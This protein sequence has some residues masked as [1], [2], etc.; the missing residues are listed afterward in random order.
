MA[1]LLRRSPAGTDR[2]PGQIEPPPVDGD[3]L[4]PFPELAAAI[5]SNRA[6]FDTYVR[7]RFLADERFNSDSSSRAVHAKWR[8]ALLEAYQ[9]ESGKICGSYYCEHLV[10]AAARTDRPRFALVFNSNSW[11]QEEQL[12]TSCDGLYWEGID[13]LAGTDRTTFVERLYSVA[14]DVLAL[15]DTRCGPNG[16]PAEPLPDPDDAP[17]LR[18]QAL[19][20]LERKLQD[21]RAFYAKAAP[22]RAR[23]RY[24]GG[25][26]AGFALTLGLAG[27]LF[28]LLWVS[29]VV[30]VED[31]G[32]IIAIWIAGAIGAVVSV[33]QRVSSESLELHHEAGRSELILLG[34]I[35]PVLGAAIAVA[36][37]SL[38]A[39]GILDFAL[40]SGNA[41]ELYYFAGIGFLSGFSERFAQ[42]MLVRT[43][44]HFTRDDPPPAPS[45]E[46][47]PGDKPQ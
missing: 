44:T 1:G 8:S 5:K 7:A 40:P 31:R 46:A 38:F 32:E 39:G 20:A 30:S 17:T 33:M 29:E 42:D 2:R 9:A 12:L 11:G 13:Y 27:L 16:A 23:L 6:S 19:E 25:V 34:A 22:N 43:S 45:G 26:A 18:S 36:L 14:T 4:P 35:R 10:G 37:Y 47:P 41:N 3:D 24:L 28:L 21:V 15:L